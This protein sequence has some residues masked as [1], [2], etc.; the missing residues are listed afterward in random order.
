MFLL[1]NTVLVLQCFSVRTHWLQTLKEVTTLAVQ[2]TSHEICTSDSS[3]TCSPLTP[4]A[5]RS[6][7]VCVVRFPYVCV[8]V[9]VVQVNALLAVPP[10]ETAD[11]PPATVIYSLRTSA[12]AHPSNS[13]RRLSYDWLFLCGKKF[14]FIW[15]SGVRGKLHSARFALRL[16]FILL[17]KKIMT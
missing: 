3:V 9:C 7:L 5:R 13:V 17:E 15:L 12:V 4:E 11:H 2:L 8:C 10:E 16:P 6:S 1:S 14:H